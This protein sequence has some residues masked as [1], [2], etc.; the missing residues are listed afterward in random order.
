MLAGRSNP[1][2][3]QRAGAKPARL[4]AA[5]REAGKTD[6]MLLQG[7]K[8]LFQLFPK[9]QDLLHLHPPLQQ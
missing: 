9:G 1:L 7:L 8:G 5:A 4:Q 6:P 3:L 2:G